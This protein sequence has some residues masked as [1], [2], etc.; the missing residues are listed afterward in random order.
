MVASSKATNGCEHKKKKKSDESP[1]NEGDA[2]RSS[3]Q[4]QDRA[5]VMVK[6]VV[7]K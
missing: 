1:G 6:D 2:K 5:V 7:T 3:H 4:R